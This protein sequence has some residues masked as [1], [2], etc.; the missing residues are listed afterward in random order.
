MN[1]KIKIW[2][3]CHDIKG[4]GVIMASKGF[5]NLEDAVN[6][7]FQLGDKGTLSIIS[8]VEVD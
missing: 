4:N 7:S 6:H 5:N 8:C 3:L 2:V 1:E